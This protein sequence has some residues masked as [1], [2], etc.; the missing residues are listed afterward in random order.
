MPRMGKACVPIDAVVC[1]PAA[2]LAPIGRGDGAAFT[3]EI[4]H[5]TG[6]THATGSR[7]ELSAVCR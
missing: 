6:I 4:S 7:R 2:P 3:S 5:D 1:A